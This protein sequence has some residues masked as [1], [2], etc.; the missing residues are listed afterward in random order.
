MRNA[1]IY[2]SFI[3]SKTDAMISKN[4]AIYIYEHAIKTHKSGALVNIAVSRGASTCY[5]AEASKT[6]GGKVLV[7]D[8]LTNN[9]KASLV[10]SLVITTTYCSYAI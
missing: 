3:L 1:P 6:W 10:E 5:L 8:I 7:I 4:E 2:F 9:M